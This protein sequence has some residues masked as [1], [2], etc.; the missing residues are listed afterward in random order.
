MFSMNVPLMTQ[1]VALQLE[2]AKADYI[3]SWLQGMQE[4][5]DNS[6]EIGI[7]RIG[8]LRAFVAHNLQGIGLFNQAIGLSPHNMELLK[9]ISRFYH[10]HGV[11]KYRIEINPYH[12]SSDFLTYLA[13]HG[14]SP[15]RFET[16]LYG[17]ATI[18]LPYPPTIITIREITASEIDLFATIHVGGYQ[19]ALAHV[20]ETQRNLYRESI[21][22]LYQRPGWQL[23]FMCINNLPVGMGMLYIHNGI[24]TGAGGAT[25]PSYRQKGGQAALG[26]YLIQVAAQAHCALTVAQTNVGSTSQHNME[27]LGMRIAYTGSSWVRL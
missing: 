16:Y 15:S 6:S 5:N 14:F 9:E 7:L 25:I 18:T 23:Y 2:Q 17:V 21:K 24:A 1:E 12:V 11:E 26:H 22:V 10:D 8:N 3:D 20:S 4:K 13:S 27:R 19:E